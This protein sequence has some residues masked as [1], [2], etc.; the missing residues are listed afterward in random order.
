MNRMPYLP[1]YVS[2]IVGVETEHSGKAEGCWLTDSECAK[3]WG[4]ALVTRQVLHLS[5]V[6]VAV[7]RRSIKAGCQGAWALAHVFFV[8]LS[9]LYRA[10]PPAGVPCFSVLLCR[11]RE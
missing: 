5:H 6:P 9:G 10:A 2:H 11:L 1:Q 3:S 4:A 8:P 7:L